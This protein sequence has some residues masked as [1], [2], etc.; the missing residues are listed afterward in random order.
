MSRCCSTLPCFVS[1][2]FPPRIS[3]RFGFINAG[4]D[5]VECGLL[6]ALRFCMSPSESLF[7]VSG[8]PLS[9]CTGHCPLILFAEGFPTNNRA[10]LQFVPLSAEGYATL[11]QS[12]HLFSLSLHS[13]PLLSSRF[14]SR[15][16][17]GSYLV[18]G[19]LKHLVSLLCQL[20]LSPHLTWVKDSDLQLL[21]PPQ[22]VVTRPKL[23]IQ[24]SR[25]N[26]KAQTIEVEKEEPALLSLEQRTKNNHFFYD[27]KYP[28]LIASM[29][30]TNVVQLGRKQGFEFIAYYNSRGNKK[31]NSSVCSIKQRNLLRI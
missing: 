30:Q 16:A 1:P 12:M 28:E 15:F 3:D 25:L 7:S 4:G 2:R 5:V 11:P 6:S 26:K 18:G 21:T 20:A 27:E 8:R 24:V 22:E 14:A 9:S 29:I 17:P 13:L 10:V 19:V 31:Q 23:G